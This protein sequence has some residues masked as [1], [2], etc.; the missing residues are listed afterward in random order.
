MIFVLFTHLYLTPFEVVHVTKVLTWDFCGRSSPFAGDRRQLGGA[1]VVGEL[2]PVITLQEGRL[3]AEALDIV[4]NDRHD[5]QLH[6]GAQPAG[7][8]LLGTERDRG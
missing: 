6:G 4:E 5:R 3:V 1:T 2:W 7:L 8:R